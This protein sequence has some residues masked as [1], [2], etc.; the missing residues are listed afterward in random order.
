MKNFKKVL[1]LVLAIATILSFATIASAATADFKDAKDVT[2]TEAVDVLSAIG[3]LNGYKDGE[4]KPNRVITRAEAAK[5][6][7]M[8]DNGDTDIKELYA[9]VNFTDVKAG[10]W[11]ESFISY[12]YHTGII[13]GVGNNKYAPDADVTGVQFLK[14][15]LVVL[16]FDAKEEGLVGTGYSVRARNLARAIGLLN[17]IGNDFDYTKGLTR[18]NAA[19]IMLNALQTSTVEYGKVVTLAPG[20][21]FIGDSKATFT[22]KLL[23][24]EWNLRVELTVDPFGRPGHKWSFYPND[25]PNHGKEVVLANYVDTP[26]ATYTTEVDGCTIYDDLGVELKYQSEHL[27]EPGATSWTDGV[28]KTKLDTVTGKY[29]TD[30]EV[31]KDKTSSKTGAQ[32]QLTEI[33]AITAPDTKIVEY[34]I[35]HINTYLAQVGPVKDEVKDG[36]NHVQTPRYVT[37]TVYARTNNENYKGGAAMATLANT[38][39]V[40]ENFAEGDFVLVQGVVTPDKQG[41]L[42]IDIKS[43]TAAKTELTKL[44]GLDNISAV[45]NMYVN[46]TKTPVACKY[47]YDA[48]RTVADCWDTF[49]FIYDSYGNVIGTTKYTAPATYAVLDKLYIDYAKGDAT[50]YATVVTPAGE[51]TD[52]TVNTITAI[53]PDKTNP[54]NGTAQKA[55]DF[56]ATLDDTTAEGLGF[57]Y[58]WSGSKFYNAYYNKLVNYV[59]NEDGSYNLIIPGEA[60]NVKNAIIVKGSKFIYDGTN[61]KIPVLEVTADTIFLYQNHAAPNATYTSVTGYENVPATLIATDIQYIVKGGKVALVYVLN[62]IQVNSYKQVYYAGGQPSYDT[63]TGVGIYTYAVKVL[64]ENGMEDGVITS[65]K[66]VFDGKPA[67]VYKVT[68]NASG[69]ATAVELA[70]TDNYVVMLH[71]LAVNNTTYWYGTDEAHA[72]I[73]DLSVVAFFN[74]S[75]DN[76]VNKTNL[77]GKNVSLIFDANGAAVAAYY[78]G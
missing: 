3:V 56:I 59:V 17:G 52:V 75:G 62:P 64:G 34:R 33:Y 32:G 12:C 5:I 24:N 60:V 1:A 44:T 6:I 23:A 37:A 15:V 77:D 78:Y 28:E 16:G 42:G 46:G 65:T 63:S 2:H 57:Q 10:H 38:G 14:M 8:F 73:L 43:M 18:D 72:K 74:V 7:A 58:Q 26:V 22:G 40:T 70:S 30:Y 71:A 9:P 50:V 41:V 36:R 66:P 19:Q 4:Y 67:G 29:V 49:T 68:L 47:A 11:A 45:A 13:A 61:T 48:D 76:T 25:Y 69:L 39:F 35:V 20:V 21:A 54:K 27:S 53:Y 55:A 31:I 51:K